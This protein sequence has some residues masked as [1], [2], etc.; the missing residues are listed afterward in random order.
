MLSAVFGALLLAVQVALGFLPNIELVTTLLMVFGAVCGGYSLISV[1]VFVL[2]EGLIY[3]FAPWWMAYTYVWLIPAVVGILMRK[4]RNPLFP[5]AFSALFGL[6]FGLLTAPPVLL[7]ERY[8]VVPYLVAN[9]P[10]DIMHC[11][12]NGVLTALLYLPL[13]SALQKSVDKIKKH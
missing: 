8:S 6:L 11:V 13:R 12:G 2:A 7:I 3:G 1:Y 4:C 5:A 10:F 9:I